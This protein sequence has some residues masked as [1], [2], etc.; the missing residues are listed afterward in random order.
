MED[1]KEAVVAA[2]VVGEV[3]V[4]IKMRF[5]SQMPP[6]TLNMNNGPHSQTKK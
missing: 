3:A 4:H 5:S 6:V 1:S 2:E